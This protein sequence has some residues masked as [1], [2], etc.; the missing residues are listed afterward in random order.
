GKSE[1]PVMRLYDVPAAREAETQ[2]KEETIDYVKISQTK[3]VGEQAKLIEE[4]LNKYPKSKYAPVLNQAATSLYQQLNNR[5]KMIELGEKTLLSYPSNPVILS[6][7]ALAYTSGGAPDKAIDRASKAIDVIDK[8]TLPANSDATR[9][10]TERDQY[11]S[12]NYA[13]MGSS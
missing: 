13:S 5:E 9:W 11:L 3:D 6:L 10:K 7:L 2:P 1:Q 8:L 4:F 12:M